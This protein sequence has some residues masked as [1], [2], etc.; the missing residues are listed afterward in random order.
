M[1]FEVLVQWIYQGNAITVSD[2]S[3]NDGSET[4]SWCIAD[5]HVEQMIVARANYVSGCHHDQLPYQ[6]ELLGM[7]SNIVGVPLIGDASQVLCA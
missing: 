4:H 3:S 1:E 7:L 2:G 6:S 5:T